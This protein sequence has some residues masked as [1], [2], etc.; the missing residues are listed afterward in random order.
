MIHQIGRELEARLAA[1]GCPYKV[2]DREPRATTTWGRPRIVIEHTND[3][4]GPPRGLSINPKKHYT[5]KIG[6]KITI[7]GKSSQRGAQEFEHRHVVEEV[8]DHVLVA[9]RYVAAERLNGYAP[10]GGR[11]FVPPDIEKSEIHDGAAYELTFTFDRAVSERTW[12]GEFQPEATLR[13]Y[14][15]S[16]DPALTFAASTRRVTRSTGTWAADGFSVG[17]RV[18]ISGSASNNVAG[19]IT[20]LDGADM[21]LGSTALANEGP[22]GGCS[23]QSGVSITS[24]TVVSPA[25]G[26]DDDGDP[27]TPPA[28]AEVAC[29]A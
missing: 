5:R 10:T 13:H 6:A 9:M 29:G 24:T 21:T 26:P 12:A 27:N 20:A 8:L 22:V 14:S 1:N 16:G 7:Y 2:H 19:T 17:M 18:A 3:T 15:M 11:F 28:T 4:F 23:V 25:F